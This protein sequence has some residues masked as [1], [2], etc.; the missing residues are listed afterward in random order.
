MERICVVAFV[1]A[2]LV[3]RGINEAVVVAG[4]LIVD[5]RYC[6]PLRCACAGAAEPVPTSLNARY[7]E[8]PG[9]DLSGGN[10]PSWHEAGCEL[11]AQTDRLCARVSCWHA[12]AGHGASAGNPIYRSY[13]ELASRD[14]QLLRASH[15]WRFADLFV[16][17]W[18][19]SR[20]PPTTFR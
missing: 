6:R 2:N 15:R 17:R 5:G 19:S 7:I 1:L 18:P 16:G 11:G 10:L 20:A 3:K 4:K 14:P 8:V 12:H 9:W 13:M